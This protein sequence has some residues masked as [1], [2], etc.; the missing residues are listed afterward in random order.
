MKIYVSDEVIEK[1][2]KEL[3]LEVFENVDCETDLGNALFDYQEELSNRRINE[4]GE[5][6]YFETDNNRI[7][8]KDKVE[9]DI[10]DMGDAYLTFGLDNERFT[11]LEDLK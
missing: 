1:F 8:L 11:L 4:K 3:V 10:S 6:A 7:Y 9:Y 2:G 5:W